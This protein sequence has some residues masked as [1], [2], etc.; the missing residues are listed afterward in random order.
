MVIIAT[1]LLLE[2]NAREYDWTVV[3][4]GFLGH[5]SLYRISIMGVLYCYYYLFSQNLLAG[6]IVSSQLTLVFT[7]ENMKKYV[8]RHR[9]EVVEYKVGDLCK[10]P[11]GLAG[12]KLLP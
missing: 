2:C 7:Q 8:D 1:I 4:L 10:E 6:M 11:R 12:M 5:S 3:F 9:S